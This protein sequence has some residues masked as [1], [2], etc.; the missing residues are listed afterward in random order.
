MLSSLYPRTGRAPHIP[1][2]F[3]EKRNRRIK[4]LLQL[5][6]SLDKITILSWALMEE[7]LMER[8][9]FYCSHLKSGVFMK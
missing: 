3:R 4:Y 7:I 5:K 8:D 6:H 1:S 2:Q 9:F